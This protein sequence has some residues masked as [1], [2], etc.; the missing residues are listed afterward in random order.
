MPD[1]DLAQKEA[2]ALLAMGKICA[3]TQEYLYP[4]IGQAL[5]IPLVSQDKRENFL[6]DLERGSINLEKGKYQ[7]RARQ[8]VVL[9]RLCFGG[10][11]H[12]NPDGEEVPRPHLHIYREGFGDK[13]A[14]AAPSAIFSNP[15]DL[16]QTL[17][18]F[19]RYCNIVQPP[20]FRRGLIP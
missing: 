6:L 17:H 10:P 20:I 11:P 5:I 12:R 7:T 15:V 18:D 9:A 8:I 16:W 3:E 19:M 13:W 14:I 4:P 2:D 1:Y